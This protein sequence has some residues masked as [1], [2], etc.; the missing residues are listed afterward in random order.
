MF[1]AIH[2]PNKYHGSRGDPYVAD[3]YSHP[4]IGG[5]I[6]MTIL[7]ALEVQPEGGPP[8]QADWCEDYGG[9]LISDD[10]VALEGF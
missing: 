5:K 7:D 2:N 6:R 10:P 4:D 9:L 3:L 8:Y 1:G